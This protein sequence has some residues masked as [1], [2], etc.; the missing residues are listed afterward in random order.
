MRASL[1]SLIFL[2]VFFCH[3]NANSVGNPDEKIK[4]L[5]DY[6]DFTNESIHGML[7][8]HRLLENYNQDINKYVDLEGS[9]INFYSNKDIPFNI[10]E[11]PD[12]W[13]Y[14][15]A[16]PTELK[17]RIISR[18]ANLGPLE[19]DLNAS[20][21]KISDIT[22]KVNDLRFT[23]EATIQNN[24]LEEMENLSKVYEELEKGVSL[25]EEMFLETVNLSEKLATLYSRLVKNQTKKEKALYDHCKTLHAGVWNIL[26]ALREKRDI[27]FDN[28]LENHNSAGIKFNSFITSLGITSSKIKR[29][30]NKIEEAYSKSYK[31]AK[32]FYEVADVDE[33]YKLYGKYYFYHNSDVINKFNR[34]GSG[35][36]F[37]LNKWLDNEPT[38]YL[39]F[40]EMPHY[41][42][43]IYPK[44]LEKIDAISSTDNKI[45]VIPKKLKD[46][47]IISNKRSIEVDTAIVE[48]KIYDHMIQDGDIV[49]INFNGDWILESYSLE[50]KPVDLKLKLNVDGKNYLLLHAES[51]GKR[52]PN[53]VGISYFYK[54]VEEKIMMKSDM[55]A[56]EMIEINLNK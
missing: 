21:I 50:A 28:S 7:I 37:E 49:S 12:H 41:Y 55:K 22:S 32:R 42:Q 3:Y 35:Y 15:N 4:I 48:L 16:S 2:C 29:A 11:D 34:Y 5:N 23:I 18:K 43:V 53:T 30:I 6:V 8:V 13:F 26:I 46:R 25:Y 1:L 36:V 54:G 10:F 14:N 39:K 51:V 24:D 44:R 38:E 19:K 31:S 45:E 17:E 56:S 27:N 52:P 9:Q 33:E 47:E 20:V 40:L